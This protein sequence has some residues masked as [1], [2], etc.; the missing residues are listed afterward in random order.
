MVRTPTGLEPALYGL[1]VQYLIVW[2]V[3]LLVDKLKQ[4]SNSD[5]ELSP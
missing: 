2:I 3:L 5:L 1:P 4:D